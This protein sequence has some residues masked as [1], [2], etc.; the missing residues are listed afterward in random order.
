MNEETFQ[1]HVV[2]L[3]VLGYTVVEGLLTPAECDEAH[4]ELERIFAAERELPGAPHGPHAAQAYS[5]M[6]K[7]RV[8]E[9]LYQLLPLLRLVRHFLGE[10]AVLSS[11][12]AH[13]VH[14]GAPA[15]KLHYDGSLTGPYKS[16]APADRGRRIVGHTLG[17]NVAFC[18][19]PYTR[20]NG[21]TRVVPGS[22]RCADTTVPRDATV[23]GET[24]VEAPRGAAVVW[25][26]A[27]WHGAS[28]NTSGEVRYAVMTPWRRSWIRP[29]ADLTRMVLPDVLERAGEEGR[30]IF[31]FPSRSPYVDRWQWDAKR[32]RPTEAWAHLNRDEL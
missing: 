30:V 18:I 6:N 15:Q 28:A 2:A 4:V 5:L 10:D 21:A 7:A 3:D 13:R 17:L 27:C 32:G 16:N 23:P 20:T 26:I 25:D 8:F 22:H 24:I 14:P 9:R 29:E 12:Q 1:Q 31:G 11:V 19:S